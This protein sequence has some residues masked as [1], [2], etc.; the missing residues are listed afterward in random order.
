M[1]TGI[2]KKAVVVV[3]SCNTIQTL[4]DINAMIDIH[5]KHLEGLRTQCS[6]SAELIQ[7]EIRTIEGKLVK[8][9][10]KQL[11]AKAKIPI[12]GLPY[13]VKNIPSIKQWLQVV[14]ISQPSVET[15]CAKFQSLESLQELSDHEIKR[16]FNECSAKEDEYRRLIRALQSVKRYTEVLVHNEKEGNSGRTTP[17]LALYWDSWDNATKISMPMSSNIQHNDS[18]IQN[19]SPIQSIITAHETIPQMTSENRSP[20]STPSLLKGRG[21]R[22]KFPAT[23]PPRKKNQVIGG[24]APLLTDFPLTKSTSH[25]SQLANRIDGNDIISMEHLAVTG[26]SSP[27]PTSN[28]NLPGASPAGAVPTSSTPS[29]GR[30]RLATDPCSITDDSNDDIPKSTV[31]TPKSPRTPTVGGPAVMAHTIN[32][33]F[34]MTFKM[35]TVCDL[36]LKQMFIGLKCKDCKYKCHRD[37]AIKVPPSCKLPPGL[38]DYVRQ[39]INDGP[40]TPIMQRTTGISN[41]IG[42]STTSVPSPSLNRLTPHDKKKSRTQP[43]IHM[44]QGGGSTSG[45]GLH[46]THFDSSSTTSSC[47]SSTPSSPALVLPSHISA[48]HTPTSASQITQFRFPDVRQADRA[49]SAE[50]LLSPLS[51]VSLSAKNSTSVINSVT[52][53][54]PAS[55]NPSVENSTSGHA[56]QDSNKIISVSGLSGTSGSN[57]TSTDSER[58]Y[59]VDSQDSQISDTET[60][61]DRHW[62]RQNSLSLR[63]WDIPFHELELGDPI[64]QGRFGTVHRG[65]WHGDVAV[66]LLNMDQIGDEKVLES[67]KLEVA[68]FRKTRHENLVLFM[69]A[70]MNLP[71]LALVTSM[72]KGLTLYT[73]LHL[74][75]DKFSMNKTV[76]I[77]Q[78]IS[79]GMGY[80]H[81]RGIIHK[82]LKSKNIFLENGKVIITDFGLFSVSKLCKIHGEENDELP[83]TMASDAYAFGTVWYELLCGEWPYKEH[84]PEAMIWQIGRGMKQ[85]LANLQASRDL[86]DILMACWAFNVKDRAEFSKLLKILERLPK[87][88]LLRSPSHPVHLSRSAES[89]F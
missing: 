10:S 27:V 28:S 59:R 70:C 12:E 85:S 16:I 42:S 56:S 19:S 29:K 65:I 55:G 8:L 26:S 7:Q 15:L 63:E 47:S 71:T 58:T 34:T 5:A 31:A 61:G 79:Q 45:F 13:E 48:N 74:R 78:Q 46:S 33:R 1:D 62:P 83:F 38:I 64:G 76:I 44:N 81:A 25:E 87:K 69:G 37:C 60:S 14:G 30:H 86:K 35:L 36:C 75:K 53:L 66:R 82:D 43:A 18:V 40:Q 67:F 32:H 80:L 49:Q 24:T 22:M 54:S 2:A 88:R 11:V 77:A 39:R 9:F 72:C 73:H 57:S 84:C 51:H 23:P 6:T 17:D 52:T 3:N 21:D 50:T 20:P 68:T 4:L 41:T 89:V